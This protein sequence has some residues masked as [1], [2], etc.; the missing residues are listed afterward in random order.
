MSMELWFAI[1]CGALALVYGLFTARSVL[2]A[3]AGEARMQEI[4]NAI[5]LGAAAYLNRQYRTVAVVGAV[6]FV[7]LALVLEISVAIGFLIGAALSGAAGYIGMI[8]STRA[9][10][11][12]AEAAR[13]GLA[14]GLSLAFRSGAV[15]GMLVAGLALLAVT[16]YYMILL[17]TGASGRGLIDPL[18]ALGFGA[19][20][21][22][23]SERRPG[24]AS[25]TWPHTRMWG[26]IWTSTTCSSRTGTTAGPHTNARNSAIFCS[27]TNWRAS[28]ATRGP[29]STRFIRALC[30][31]ISGRGARTTPRSGGASP[32]WCFDSLP[33]LRPRKALKPRSISPLRQ[34]LPALPASTSH[35]A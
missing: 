11:R 29:R 3:S 13:T 7:I 30:A 15:T 31:P 8:V 32:P 6:I 14:A 33:P 16:V 28:S 19:S 25:S 34:T 9:N 26:S 2:A 12:T 20:L 10:V 22:S 1:A 24:P 23:S 21:M 5:Q 4:S 35:R 27:P 18:V 17:E